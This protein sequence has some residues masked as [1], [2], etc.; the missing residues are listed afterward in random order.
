MKKSRFSESQIVATLNEADAGLP[1]HELC[2]RSST[3]VRQ[4]RGS[5]LPG[6]RALPFSR[7]QL[8]LCG[9]WPR[10]PFIG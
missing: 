1:V 8:R 3:A 6:K 4:A 9:G 5:P 7:K 2:R 10:R